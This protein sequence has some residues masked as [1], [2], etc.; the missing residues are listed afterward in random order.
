MN[1]DLWIAIFAAL[2]GSP[3]LHAA[4]HF[5]VAS[6]RSNS[7]EEFDTTGKWLRT[8]ATTGPY[9]PVAL[10]QMP[11]TGEIFVTTMWASGPS[12]GQLTNKILR[13]Q[14]NGSF[15]VD[16]DAFTIECT[17]CPTTV[18]Q[19]LV[20]DSD[21]NLWIATAYGTDLGAPIYIFEYLAEI[22]RCRIRRPNPS[23][24]GHHVPRRSD[25]V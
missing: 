21:G 16:W 4:D 7:I 14:A 17:T 18:T 23:D 19:S 22:L 12:I 8:F 1:K 20:F 5:L 9:A 2:L 6:S 25:G 10:A 24:P 11:G 15:D 3:S 13:Y